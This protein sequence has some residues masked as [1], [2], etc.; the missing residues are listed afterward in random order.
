MRRTRRVFKSLRT[1]QVVREKC[2]RRSDSRNVGESMNV[3]Q[4][5]Y[6]SLLDTRQETKGSTTDRCMVCKDTEDVAWMRVR[7]E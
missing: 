3:A 2:G 6:I 1:T 5:K 4:E 7:P